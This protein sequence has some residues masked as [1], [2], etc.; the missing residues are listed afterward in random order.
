MDQPY[1]TYA[2]QV[3]QDHGSGVDGHVQNVRGR[4]QDGGDDEKHK[5][6]SADVTPEELGVDHSHHAGKPKYDRQLKNDGETKNDSQ[7]QLGVFVNRD[8][9]FE[10]RAVGAD[11][12]V[13]RNRK[14][15]PVSEIASRKEEPDREQ[16]K[17]QQ[18]FLFP[19]VQSRRNEI[20]YLVQDDGRSHENARHDSHLQV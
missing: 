8:D 7:E 4:G 17:R 18:E 9:G 2:Q 5:N 13:H 19:A 14:N 1:Q 20:P 12:K 6:R 11:Q 16:Q 15:N 3:Q 10:I